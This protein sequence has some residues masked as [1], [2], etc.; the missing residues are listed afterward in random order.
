[1]N[2]R[3][4]VNGR[5]LLDRLRE[6]GA[7]GSTPDGG[8]DRQALTALDRKA[9][10]R[11]ADIALSR[12]FAVFQDPAANLFVRR[13][14]VR[15]DVPPLLI[16][17][18]LDTQPTGGRYDGALGSLAALEVLET[19]E[20]AACDAAAPI[21][22]VV[23]TNEEGCR[24]A[25]GSMGSKAFADR[26]LAPG[27]LETVSGDGAILGDELAATLDALPSARPRPLGFPVAGYFEL[28]IEQGPILERSG[29][30]IGIVT[31]VQGT[32]WL[33]VRVTG[34]AGHAGTTPLDAR[35][36]PMMAA[37]R[38]LSALYD[39]VMPGDEAAR[40]TVGR[41]TVEPGSINAIPSAV[42]A[43]VDIR[44]P[45]T[46]RL[47]ELEEAIGVT[48]RRAAAEYRCDY[49]AERIFD[50]PATGFD[51]GMIECLEAAARTCGAASQRMVSGAFHDAL[52]VARRAPAAMIFVPCRGGVSHNANEFVEPGHSVLGA[53]VLLEACLSVLA[54]GVPAGRKEYQ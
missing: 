39:D 31:G 44:H 11:L 29:V 20:D 30:P 25:P 10:G 21:E 33:K 7:I 12:G 28:H 41:L 47:D 38:G 5:R 46:D 34:E 53:E 52:F 22:L 15:G 37:S 49:E 18:H 40:L 45:S 51:D 48:M 27:M 3:I 8:V 6:F 42:T 26:Y 9:R 23:W 50:L 14:G 43:F 4:H 36:D 2:K 16:G 17:S 32:R 35:R 24:F 19:L 54:G 1:M 13:P